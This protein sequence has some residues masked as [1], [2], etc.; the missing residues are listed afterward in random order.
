MRRLDLRLTRAEARIPHLLAGPKG[1]QLVARPLDLLARWGEVIRAP[2]LSNVNV[3]RG[4]GTDR[5]ASVVG[6]FHGLRAVKQEG[7]FWV[8]GKPPA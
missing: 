6:A 7:E 3:I 8:N 2:P 5:A 1:L 4:R